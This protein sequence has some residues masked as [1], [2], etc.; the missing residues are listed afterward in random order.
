MDQEL[1]AAVFNRWERGLPVEE[2]V[3]FKAAQ[4]VGVNPHDA[5]LEARWY[6][7]LDH[8]L[9]KLAS[10]AKLSAPELAIYS[11]AAGEDPQIMAKTAA[12]YC[13][14]AQELVLTK[15]A[16]RDWVPDLEMLK[17]AM[18][19][20]ADAG[21]A[22]GGEMMAPGMDPAAG[23]MG[24]APNAAMPPAQEPDPMAGAAV[25]QAPQDRYKPSPMAPSQTPPSSE[26]NLNE[27]VDAARHPDAAADAQGAMQDPGGTMAPEGGPGSMGPDAGPGMGQEAPPPMPPEQKIQQVDPSVDPETMARWA[28]KLQEIE[29]QTGIQMNDPAQVQ[30]FVGEMQKADQKTLDEAIKTIGTPQPFNKPTNPNSPAAQQQDQPAS[31]PQQE[32]VAAKR[33]AYLP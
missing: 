32:K 14:D 5:L 33:R 12:K 11:A 25:Q 3:F 6:T 30:K 8:D 29:E 13:L 4:A 7:L 19:M 9:R 20:P 26:G 21:G 27:L 22:G 15:L 24:G 17:R 23:G 1:A 10:G 18:M 16:E 31:P 2:T 28:P